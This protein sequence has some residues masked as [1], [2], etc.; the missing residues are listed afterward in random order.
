MYKWLLYVRQL[1]SQ[2]AAVP[3][4]R[5]ILLRGAFT[6]GKPWRPVS[7]KQGEMEND[8]NTKPWENHGKTMGKWW[9]NGFSMVL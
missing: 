2:M 5:G 7:W 6:S 9:M 8:G 1:G 4:A 3:C